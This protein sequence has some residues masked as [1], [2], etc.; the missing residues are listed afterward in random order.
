M[1]ALVSRNI[2]PASRA[3]ETPLSETPALSKSETGEPKGKW[4]LCGCGCGVRGVGVVGCGVWAYMCTYIH[5]YIH[6]FTLHYI[7]LH[8]ITLHYIKIQHLASH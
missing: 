6:Y 4:T 7:T 3:G 1:P 2:A 5:T 8:Y